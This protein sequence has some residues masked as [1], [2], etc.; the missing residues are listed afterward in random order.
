MSNHTTRDPGLTSRFS[1]DAI[2]IKPEMTGY[3]LAEFSIS[4]KPVRHGRPGIGATTSES[5]PSLDR[6]R[7]LD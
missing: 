6:R 3:Y 2:E 4:Y 5:P 7:P 1:P